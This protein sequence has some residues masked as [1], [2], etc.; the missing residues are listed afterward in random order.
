MRNVCLGSLPGF[1]KVFSQ[2]VF[3]M[4]P[5]TSGPA[6]QNLVSLHTGLYRTH[7]CLFIS[8]FSNIFEVLFT[9][10]NINPFK[11]F[12]SEMFSIVTK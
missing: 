7:V 6:V 1:G 4:L 9:H 10:H 8:L 11:A 12:N 2:I 3:T 5:G